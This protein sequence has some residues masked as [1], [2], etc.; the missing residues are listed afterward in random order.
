MIVVTGGAGFIGSAIVWKLN[1]LGEKDILVVD[2]DAPHSPKW[3]NVSRL[4]FTGYEEADS[5]VDR[6]EQG[7]YGSGRIRAIFHMGACSDTTERNAAYLRHNNTLYTQRLAEWA[8]ANK[9]Y[10]SYASSAATYGAGQLGYSD[11]DALTPLL[12]P[13]NLYG[14]SKLDFDRWALETGIAYKITGFRFF[15]V[16][17]P[18]EYH[19]GHMRSLVH[20]GFGQ[21]QAAGKLKLFKSYL[22]AYGDGEQKRDFLYV[23][24]AVEAVAWFYQNPHWK[25]IFNLGAGRAETWNALGT[26]L[27]KAMG[28][29]KHIEYIDMPYD[30]RKQYQYFTE[31]DMSKF[32][33]TGC[34]VRFR[35][36]DAGV[37]DYVRNHLDTADAYLG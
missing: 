20:K 8:V 36:L 33:W 13:L 29:E 7:A 6:L 34:P 24:D 23:K 26:A 19:K 22:P 27:F 9:A 4:S 16:Y 28:R 30:I 1:R 3:R 37:T 32:S 18:N 35:D 14:H 5:F 31:A 21:V 17:G 25:G 2:V 10:F 11:S 12:E 15:N